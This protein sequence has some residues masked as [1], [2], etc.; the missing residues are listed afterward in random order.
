MSLLL[1]ILI[2]VLILLLPLAW[3]GMTSRRILI[4]QSA[5]P[6]C[7]G[8]ESRIELPLIWDRSN[9]I[10]RTNITL[11]DKE[12]QITFSAIPDTGS[13][14]AVLAGP[15]CQGCNPR[16]GIF[17][18][19]LGTNVSNGKTGVIRYSGGQQ[20]FYVPWRALF[21]EDGNGNGRKVNFGVIV[22][23]NSPDGRPLNVL[24][25]AA[26]GEGFVSQLC[27][28]KTVVFDFPR[29]KLYLGPSDDILFANPDT[30]RTFKLLTPQPGTAPPFTLAR[31]LEMKVNGRPLPDSIVP[32][33]AILDTGTTNQIVPRNLASALRVNGQVEITFESY[34]GDDYPSTVVFN[35]TASDISVGQLLVPDSMMIGNSWL[36]QYGVGF[37]HDI[38]R[39]VIF[40]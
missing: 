22:N 20:N 12:R 24:G 10:Y 8:N 6:P 39:T 7:N 29:L 28:E 1:V 9:G 2:V 14:I 4:P 27:G 38:D 32:E 16:D 18:T 26:E 23:T 17:D 25:L 30:V 35:N 13:S 5:L 31:I 21:Q 40:R 36:K 11:G 19:S 33:F 15:E 3:Y 34:P 37:Q